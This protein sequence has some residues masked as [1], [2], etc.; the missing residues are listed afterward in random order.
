M[1]KR[2]F[3]LSNSVC[4]GKKYLEH[5]EE[6]LKKFLLSID[7]IVFIPYAKHDWNGYTQTVRERFAE[8]GKTVV[9]IHEGKSPAQHIQSAQAIFIGGGNTFR[10]LN[11]LY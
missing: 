8:M 7:T 9:G 1:N 2:L 11:Q 10:L 5:C 3:L 4:P 6:E